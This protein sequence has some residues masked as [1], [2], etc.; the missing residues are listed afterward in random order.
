[1]PGPVIAYAI[2]SVLHLPA[3]HTTELTPRQVPPAPNT[4]SVNILAALEKA[5]ESLPVLPDASESD[6]I[7][8]FSENVP[9][10]LAKEDTWEYLDPILNRFLGFNR[11]L[12]S[13]YNELRGGERGLSAMVQYLK[14]FVHLYEIDSTLLEGKVQRLVNVIQAQCIAMTKSKHSLLTY[15]GLDQWQDHNHKSIQC[16]HRLR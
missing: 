11:M 6:E 16:Y 1:M 15:I 9:T 10:D 2:E 4:H 7:A 5:V 8:V 12:G 3:T 14:D 13:I